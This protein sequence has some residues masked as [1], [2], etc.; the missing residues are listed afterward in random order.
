LKPH[1]VSAVVISG[2]VRVDRI[3]DAY[4]EPKTGQIARNV[5]AF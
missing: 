3:N 4:A 2:R 5:I 1:V